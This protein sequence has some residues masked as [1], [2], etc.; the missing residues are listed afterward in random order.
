MSETARRQCGDCQLCCK[1]LPTKE[2]NKLANTRC[3]YQKTG[4]GCSIYTKRPFSCMVWNCRW[5]VN[6]DT[7]DLSRPDRSHYVIDIMP[8]YI[9][10]QYEGKQS[11]D[12]PVV[13]IWVDP[14]F[15]DA[16]RDPQLR[17]Y[18]ERRAQ[19]HGMAAMIRYNS[20]EGFV[21]FAPSLSADH[22]WHEEH[23][24]Q[25]TEEHSTLDKMRKIGMA[26]EIEVDQ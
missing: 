24:S 14:R 21:I 15:P 9:T 16:H 22:Q 1:L 19:E 20:S 26:V 13:Q 8:D 5:L 17:A 18:I 4:K 3:Q 7:A 11:I 12:L 10:M 23:S 25:R 6:D 2:I